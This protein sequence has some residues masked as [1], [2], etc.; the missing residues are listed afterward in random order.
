MD[1]I[2]HMA[3]NG[4]RIETRKNYFFSSK[5]GLLF[6]HTLHYNIAAGL[7]SLWNGKF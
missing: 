5:I 1:R 7:Y 4:K 6:I 3:G 2:S